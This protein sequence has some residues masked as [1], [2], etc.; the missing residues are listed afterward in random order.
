MKKT[1]CII[2]SLI[3]TVSLS[4]Y[5]TATASNVLFGDANS[6]GKVDAKDLIVE[7]QYLAGK[8]GADKINLFNARVSSVRQESVLTLK[9]KDVQTLIKY[10]T[11]NADNLTP[12]WYT[13]VGDNANKYSID[14][15]K[16][17][18]LLCGRAEYGENS[19]L[20]S[21]TASG[22]KFT[23]DCD[24][25]IIIDYS[26]DKD[27]R[28]SIAV[29]ED[30][31]NQKLVTLRSDKASVHAALNIKKGLHTIEIRKATEHGNCQLITV[32]AITLNGEKSS[33]PA[34]KKHRIEF[35][36]D[37]ITAGYGNIELQA[38]EEQESANKG[39]WQYQDGT[40]TYA[41]FTAH[42]FD[43]DY[44]IAA[45][46]GHGVLGGY[47]NYTQTFDKYF[48]YS[49]VK[50]K[51]PWSRKNYNADLIVINFGSND[52]SRE[53]NNL[54]VDNFVNKASEIVESMHKDNPNAKILWV[55]GMNYVSDTAKL[56]T[57]LQKLDEKYD[58]LNYRKVPARHSGGDSHPT[59]NEHKYHAD[60]LTQII[61]ELYPDMFK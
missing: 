26:A 20:L 39:S 46:S 17:N 6:D 2:L 60:N 7:R 53:G 36:G 61:N 10:L 11:K 8:I 18:I 47:S 31:D 32:K 40:R 30:Y 34:T 56:C 5:F 58:Y 59:V 12:K 43:A 21:Q 48:D 49:I 50:N 22:F 1:L 33:V 13:N 3:F 45:A 29:D 23:A 25:S 44:S 16:S 55:T 9:I 52:N 38:G 19:V 41:T 14:Q 28:I 54:N 51:T 42:K 37:S 24:G 4:L 35:Y 27:C 57:A 15:L